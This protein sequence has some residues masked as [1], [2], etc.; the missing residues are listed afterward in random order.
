M[1]V[2]Y[3]PKVILGDAQKMRNPI[4]VQSHNSQ[5][6]SESTCVNFLALTKM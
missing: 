3:P 2:F 4:L 5:K 6:V 1:K